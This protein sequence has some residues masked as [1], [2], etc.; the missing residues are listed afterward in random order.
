[1]RNTE[2]LKDLLMEIFLLEDDEFS[3]DLSQDEIET[4]D[5]LGTVSMAVGIQEE[6]GYHMTPEEATKMA[7]VQEIKTLLEGKGIAFD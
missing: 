1:M 3:F 6:F 7:S 2:K 5:S 4:W